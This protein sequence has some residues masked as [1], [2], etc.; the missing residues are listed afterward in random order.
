M[1]TLKTLL[2]GNT[3]SSVCPLR[4]DL[5]NGIKIQKL[6]FNLTNKVNVSYHLSHCKAS[7]LLPSGIKFRAF[8]NFEPVKPLIQQ[9]ILQISFIFEISKVILMKNIIVI[10]ILLKK[11]LLWML[12]FPE[13]FGGI[14]F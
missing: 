11:I 13:I 12:V 14:N 4:I 9:P 10:V 2:K 5:S 7:S 1:Y 8:G 6:I 3:R